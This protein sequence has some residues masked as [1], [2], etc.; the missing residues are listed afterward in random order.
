M[1]NK[2]LQNAMK[3]KLLLYFMIVFCA[4][5]TIS[6]A[7]D[8]ELRFMGESLNVPCEDFERH[9]EKNGFK[10]D[11]GTTYKGEYLGK[12]IGIVLEDENNGHY[13]SMTLMLVSLDP[14]KSELYY[15]KLCEEIGKEHNGFKDKEKEKNDDISYTQQSTGKYISIPTNDLIKEY[16]NGAGKKITISCYN[17]S[18]VTIVM[19]K[20][21]S[22]D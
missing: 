2:C 15:E 3:R 12:E 20:F 10:H 7:N 6:C 11:Y 9:L 14:G 8:S 4:M 13:T 19:A 16:Y 1:A 21:E 17:A 22:E 5:F 18:L